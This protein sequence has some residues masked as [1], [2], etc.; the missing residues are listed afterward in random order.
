MNAV[1]RFISRRGEPSRRTRRLLVALSVLAIVALGLTM[2]GPWSGREG[3]PGLLLVAVLGLVPLYA[4]QEFRRN[5]LRRKDA[6]EREAARRNDAYRISYRIVE[7]G[8][9]VVA[10]VFLFID[11]LD[12]FPLWDW[13]G[14]WFGGICLILFMPY[15]LFAWRE[16][17]AAA[18]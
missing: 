14:V 2:A 7:L 17:D 6:D 3:V 5:V 15:L 10:L 9:P 12:P 11:W 1:L 4:V 16:P 8:I 18:D 13:L